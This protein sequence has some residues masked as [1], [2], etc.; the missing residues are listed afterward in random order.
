MQDVTSLDTVE[1]T[2]RYQVP[3]L[4]KTVRPKPRLKGTSVNFL[5]KFGDP[6]NVPES[7]TWDTF[8]GISKKNPDEFVK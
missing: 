1:F 5:D 6:Q 7:E 2:D 3:S 8:E 4:T